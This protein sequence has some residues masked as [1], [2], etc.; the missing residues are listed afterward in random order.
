MKRTVE[1]ITHY[2]I[3]IPKEEL[4]DIINQALFNKIPLDAQAYMDVPTGGDYSGTELHMDRQVTLNL[5]W[6][7]KSS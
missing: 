4:I 2:T 7:V 5:R 3:K 1:T 6:S